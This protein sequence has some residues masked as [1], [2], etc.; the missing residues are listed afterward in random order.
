M[1][2]RITVLILFSFLFILTLAACNEDKAAQPAAKKSGVVTS[3]Q[4]YFDSFGN[5]PQGKA[6]RAYARVGYLPLQEDS[7]RV[8]PFPL[9]LFSETN[10]VQKILDRLVSN[11]LHL[12]DDF[13][14]YSPFPAD[15]EVMTTPLGGPQLTVS[16]MSR[17]SWSR[18]DQEA[19][20]LSIAQTVLQFPEVKKVFV[21][22]NGKP[23]PEM[24]E[25]GYSSQ[26]ERVAE[27][28]SPTIVLIAGM[29][30]KNSDQLD[31]LLVEFDR[32]I[33]VNTLKLYDDA[34]QPVE[35]KYYT[36]IFQMAVVIHPETPA[37]FKPGMK[38]TTEWDVV[39]VLGRHGKGTTTLAIKRFEH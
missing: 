17:S 29:W 38:L 15:I 28:T 13:D 32:P 22:L 23:L 36:S 2:F 12:P 7:G 35:G 27:M 9:F 18:T 26:P 1:R 14:L 19:A 11:E 33:T 25:S 3:T 34:G 6:G 5:P 24:P 10:Q 37:A 39:D 20:G 30:E 21:M 16:L 8:R 31:E 4:A